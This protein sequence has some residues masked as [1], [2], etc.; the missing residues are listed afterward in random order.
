M[1][2]ELPEAEAMRPA[3]G[4]GSGSGTLRSSNTPQADN[5]HKQ[6]WPDLD[7]N[8]EE[9]LTKAQELLA[10]QRKA[11]GSK[12]GAKNRNEGAKAAINVTTKSRPDT[13]PKGPGQRVSV[14]RTATPYSG[15]GG[16]RQGAKKNSST[17]QREAR[18]A[19]TVGEQGGVSHPVSLDDDTWSEATDKGSRGEHEEEPEASTPG[20]SGPSQRQALEQEVSTQVQHEGRATQQGGNQY[21]HSQLWDPGWGGEFDPTRSSGVSKRP[22]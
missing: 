10:Q 18:K 22:N 8:L 1:G 16:R 5:A 21:Q 13:L 15:A 6:H 4:S 14:A 11:Q 17:V 2:S 20:T 12:P 3:S 7:A 19:Q 9:L